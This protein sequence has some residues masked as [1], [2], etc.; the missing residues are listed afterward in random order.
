M[1]NPINYRYDGEPAPYYWGHYRAMCAKVLGTLLTEPGMRINS[2][3]AERFSPCAISML[4]RNPE[5]HWTNFDLTKKD[6]SNRLF[7]L[8]PG[9]SAQIDFT[10]NLGLAASEFNMD[11]LTDIVFRR[12]SKPD[13]HLYA[14]F[15]NAIERS[16]S[17]VHWTPLAQNP[18]H[19]LIIPQRSFED[20]MFRPTKH[21][22]ENLVRNFWLIK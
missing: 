22:K 14:A 15:V 13:D 9:K 10:H 8:P 16:G 17:Y 7:G 18:L 12:N 3:L 2:E 19:V 1:I 5:L 4:I 20:A 11:M 21:D 6:R